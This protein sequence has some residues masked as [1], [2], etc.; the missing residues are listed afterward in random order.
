[1]KLRRRR[2]GTELST[3]D[4]PKRRRRS[5]KSTSERVSARQDKLNAEEERKMEATAAFSRL[6]QLAPSIE[7][8]DEEAVYQWLEIATRL[9]DSFRSTRQLFPSDYKKKF[10]GM[11]R[12]KRGDRKKGKDKEADLAEEADEIANRLE[13]SMIEDEEDEVE[14]TS[15]RGRD[16]DQWVNFILQVR[17]DSAPI[18]FRREILMVARRRTSTAFSLP[19]LTS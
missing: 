17:F 19:S 15:F 13:R 2:D 9:I 14:E 4:E 8:G 6:E 18:L 5:Y 1:M 10:T 7:I 3:S 12:R 11:V 16:F